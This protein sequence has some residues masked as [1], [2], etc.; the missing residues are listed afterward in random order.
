[1]SAASIFS[2]VSP[3]SSVTSSSSWR[4]RRR[5]VVLASLRGSSLRA[6]ANRPTASSSYHRRTTLGVSALLS[7]ALMA[8][9]EKPVP[10]SGNVQV[11]SRSVGS[12]YGCSCTVPHASVVALPKPAAD[13]SQLAMPSQL[14][15]RSNVWGLESLYADGAAVTGRPSARRLSAAVSTALVP[16]GS[17]SGQ[18]GP[19]VATVSM[20]ARS[21][22][23]LM[24]A[25]SRLVSP[26]SRKPVATGPSQ[27]SPHWFVKP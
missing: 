27:R 3:D 13:S 22:L 14:S 25:P 2:G 12:T 24:S 21:A 10:S 6:S 8:G 16:A 23:P 11:A 19:H 20:P 7:L 9:N 4:S 15:S 18:P 17:V 26:T 1:M 5:T